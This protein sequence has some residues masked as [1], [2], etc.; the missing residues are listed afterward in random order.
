MSSLIKI[1][2]EYKNWITE[3]SNRFRQT[4][5]KA[6]VKTNSDMLRFYWSLG[7][8]IVGMSEKNN[9]GSGFYKTISEDLKDVFPDIK[10]FSPTNL[11]YMRYFYEMY[12]T[13]TNR[14]QLVDDLENI[15]NRQQ[16]VD[17]LGQDIIF[18]IPWGHHVQ[19]LGKCKNNPQ[20]ALFYV[21]KTLENNWSR[22]ILLNFLGTDLYEREGKAVTNFA[23]TLPAEQSDLAQAMT[24]DPYRFDFLTLREKY[25]E[26]ELKDALI[27]KAEKFIDMLFYNTK[28]HCYVVL[29]VKTGKF[30][31]SYAGQLGTYVVAVNHQIKSEQDNPTVGLLICKDLDKVEAQYALES[32]S[33]P[34]GVSSYELSKL[35][36]EEFKG[37]MPTIEEI[38]AEFGD[39]D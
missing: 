38:E 30:D 26:K 1:D 28:R 9:Y 34:I 15:V 35:I 2:N 27:N 16:A 29:E 12:P 3:I 14:Q 24:K 36:P 5:V 39:I 23:L 25:D 18:Y 11:K 20:K 17:D 21:K 22:D 10:S 33:Q 37:S 8:D 7:R 32:S 13:A 19:I 4:Q 31:S 6:A